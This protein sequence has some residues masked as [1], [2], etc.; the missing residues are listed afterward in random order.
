MDVPGAWNAQYIDDQYARWRQS[1]ETVSAEWRAF[2]EGFELGASRLAQAPPEALAFQAKAEAL[3]H[4]YRD[5][6]HL[7]SCLDPLSLCPTSHPLLDLEAFG[8]SVDDR[9]RP[10]FAPGFGEQDV[11]PLGE[12]VDALR[13]TYCRSVGVEY[14][15]LQDPGE[16]EWL[17]TRMEPARNRRGLSREE[18]GAVLRWL[19]RAGRFEE[20]L[21]KRYL[22]QTRF[23]LEGAEVLIPQLRALV[24]QAAESGVREVVLGM[25]HRGRLNVHVNLLGKTYEEVFCQFEASYD[26]EA[27]PG[28]GD[29][30]Y[31]SGYVGEVATEA[32]SVRIILP[33]NPSHLEAVNPVVEGIARALQDRAKDG[34][35]RVLPVLIHGDAAFPGQGIVSETLN[36]ARLGGYTTG[37]TVH[38]VLNNQIG[39]TTL[40]ENARSTRY[41]TDVAKLLMAPIFHVHGEAPEA[42]LF[43]TG[44]ALE[45]RQQFGKDAVVDLVCY[46]RHGHN[47]GDEPYFTQPLLY[48]RIRERPPIYELYAQELEAGGDLES[49][50]AEALH[51]EVDQALD[52][53]FERA[54]S[55]ACVWVAPKPW[56]GWEQVRNRY[57]WEPVATSF[58]REDL[59]VFHRTLARAPEGFSL[60]PKLRKILERRVQAAEEGQGLD[61]AGAEALAFATLLA[62][63][64]AV[65][66]SGEDSGRGTFSQR[67]AVWFDTETGK[68]YVPLNHLGRE[69]ARFS[70]FDSPLSEAAVV[71]FEYGYAAVDPQTLVLWEAQYGD[72]SNGAQVITDQFVVSGE[73]KWERPN[74]LVLLLPHGYEGQ[75]P[76]HSTA[77][78]E[79]FLQACAEDNLQVCQPTTPAQ[80]FHLLR[81]QMKAAWRKPL[82]VL[83]PKSLL[84]HPEAVSPL[85]ELAGGSFRPV[86][87]DPAEPK[88]AGVRHVLLCTGKVFYALT[89]ARRKAERDDVALVRVEQLYPFPGEDI[90]KVAAGYGKATAWVWV[91]DEPAN[92]GAWPFV[93][94]RLRQVLGREFRYAGRPEAASP[95][96]GFSFLHR[97]EEERLLAEALGEKAQ[98]RRK[99][100]RA[101]KRRDEGH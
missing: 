77:R 92:M 95:A 66:L 17:R 24:R 81:R 58:P 25:A 83:T 91:Q 57:T 36:L 101:A 82:V 33:E 88:A 84:R 37:G 76:D 79:R 6:G 3:I 45:Y 100:P 67:H 74:G 11:L 53:A 68:A 1:P 22:G 48:Q 23:S 4:R 35:G 65:R 69:Q 5:L 40:P 62:E 34:A 16:R 63:G 98:G 59:T 20:F 96:T 80:Y 89:E 99:A 12:V 10:V 14:T 86:L 56:D 43:A 8:L 32:G 51:T 7:M 85:A 71:G 90:R 61:W 2:F 50:A 13:E 78:P 38:I 72:F 26:P 49:G 39:Y 21:Q 28:G 46:R 29:V 15:H 31:H 87:N 60:H 73:A 44:L 30:K 93:A 75:G 52:D 54:R 41:A 47:E 18:R 97:E 9:S 27:L 42:V 19:V 70:V 55:Q 64:V 94:P